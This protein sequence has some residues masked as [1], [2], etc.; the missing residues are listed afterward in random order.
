[1]KITVFLSPLARPSISAMPAARRLLP[2]ALLA[3]AALLA[4]MLAASASEDASVA[5]A[6]EPEAAYVFSFFRDNGQD[7]VYLALS[8]DGLNWRELLGGRPVLTPQVGGRLTRDPSFCRG[9][10][11]MFHMV[12]T[13]SW[14]DKGFGVAHSKDLLNWS[15]QQFVPV[16][17]DEPDARNTWAPEIFYD[18][19]TEQ[20]LV[21]WATT[22]K[23]L[24]P[25]TQVQ[26]DAGLNHRL[27][28]TT[29]RDFRTW[30]PKR[31]F[32]DGGF[33]VIDGFLF[34]WD[35]KVGMIVKDETVE[36]VPQKNLRVV[37]SEDG[38]M[39]PWDE[40]GPPFT[41]NRESWA[42]GPAVIRVGD[43]WFIYYDKYNKGGYGAVETPDFVSFRPVQVSLP[44]GIRHGTI[45]QVDRQTARRLV[46]HQGRLDRSA[47]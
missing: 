43:R 7:G 37:W 2:I 38:A 4:G 36:P 44:K 41:D 26:G 30:T 13:T 24:F 40:A 29:T 27:Y 20:F 23:G 12:W 28:V 14:T 25:E 10:D 22:I 42:E 15:E 11:G 45:V 1:M 8:T 9:P 39:G 3:A 46:E 35:G 31:L 32:Y 6:A 47:P 21:V 33:N 34:Q 16:N 5:A 17:A 19:A 18:E